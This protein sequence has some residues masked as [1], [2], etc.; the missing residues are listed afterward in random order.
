MTLLSNPLNVTLLT[1]HILTAPAIWQNP[2]G[3]RTSFRVLGVFNS[4]SLQ[5]LHHEANAFQPELPQ[6]RGFLSKDDWVKAVVNGANTKSPRWK[7]LLVLGGLLTGF[8][9]QQRNGLPVALRKTIEAATVKAANLAMQAANAADQLGASTICMVLG[10]SLDL[11]SNLERGQINHDHL[12]PLLIHNLFFSKAGLHWGYFLG[13]IDMDVVQVSNNTFEWSPRSSTYVQLQRMASEP[14]IASFGS[15]SRL[16]SLC[17]DSAGD[18]DTLF[19]SMEDLAAFTRSLA[20]Q[21]RQTKLSE[22]DVVEESVFLSDVTIKSTLPLLWQVLKSTMFAIITI[23]RAFL[24]R[25][26]GD[27]RIPTTQGKGSHLVRF[28]PTLTVTSSIRCHPEPT[29]SPGHS[30]H[31]ISSWQRFIVAVCVCTFDSY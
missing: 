26:L 7:H 17:V 9:S 5:I 8:E 1:S 24:A 11:L 13:P 3:L 15:L 6:P 31:L 18:V 19:K 30:I 20:V 21:W 10:Q 12:L 28:S 4:A 23:Q 29:Y 27:A 25:V 16:V 22:V 14:L 2:D